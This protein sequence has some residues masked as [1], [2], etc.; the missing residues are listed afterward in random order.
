MVLMVS[1][2]QYNDTRHRMDYYICIAS[3]LVIFHCNCTAILLVYRLDFKICT[4][5]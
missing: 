1:N 4:V 2:T 3:M 5:S